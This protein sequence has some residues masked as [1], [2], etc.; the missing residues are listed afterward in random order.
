[1]PPTPEPVR[2]DVEKTGP[3]RTALLRGDAFG[4]YFHMGAA[5]IL[6]PAYEATLLYVDIKPRL[7]VLATLI[8]NNTGVVLKEATAFRTKF[9]EWKA[10]YANTD[11]LKQFLRLLQQPARSTVQLAPYGCNLRGQEVEV[12]RGPLPTPVFAQAPAPTFQQVSEDYDTYIENSSGWGRKKQKGYAEVN[13]TPV[14]AKAF[15][16]GPA[17]QCLK[18]IRAAWLDFLPREDPLKAAVRDVAANLMNADTLT[19]KIV[20]WSRLQRFQDYRNMTDIVLKHLI[21]A[22]PAG[23]KVIL[24]G[25]TK[26]SAFVNEQRENKPALDLSSIK[27]DFEVRQ[28]YK[29]PE[30]SND[31]LLLLQL[32]FFYHLYREY[33]L[34]GIIGAKSGFIDGLGFL[35]IPQLSLEF[36]ESIPSSRIAK[37]THIPHYFVMPS[38][39]FVGKERRKPSN[40]SRTVDSEKAF[41]TNFIGLCL[42]LK[43]GT[44]TSHPGLPSLRQYVTTS[45]ADKPQLE[46]LNAEF[47]DDK[48]GFKDSADTQP[49]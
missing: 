23:C 48:V 37:L 11:P 22:A 41:V 24:S 9:N 12:I 20:I 8:A 19:P 26:I 46:L 28:F 35:G 17:A 27:G 45:P 34:V 32:Y 49:R 47:N 6:K 42:A 30:F 18:A 1:M 40:D 3:L 33:N 5:R 43:N 16:A 4:E 15:N 14:I 31:Y 29:G 10:G 2:P 36:K 13:A 21:D 44:G 38:L 25:D 7:D 39:A